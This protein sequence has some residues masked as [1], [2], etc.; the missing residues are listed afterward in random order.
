MNNE[1]NNT[2]NINQ[3]VVPGQI[4]QQV[5]PTQPTVVQPVVQ[6]TVPVQSVVQNTVQVQ[7]VQP[8]QQV[9]PQTVTQVP[10]QPT[11]TVQQPINNEAIICPKCNARNPK[12][13]ATCTACGTLLINSQTTETNNK[14]KAMF[15]DKKN[16]MYLGIGVVILLAIIL[17]ATYIIKINIRSQLMYNGYTETKTGV[18]KIKELTTQMEV[19]VINGIEQIDVS[20]S[21][22]LEQSYLTV[23]L[24]MNNLTEKDE[25]LE[26]WDIELVDESKKT[27]VTLNMFSE[28]DDDLFKTIKGNTKETGKFYFDLIGFDDDNNLNKLSEDKINSI[29]YL[30]LSVPSFAEKNAN[31]FDIKL[32]DYFIEVK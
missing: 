18:L 9:I 17:T 15:S 28:E 27:I 26:L 2:N 24:E 4:P 23:K 8:V 11:V 13:T 21:D 19:R 30:K 29:K 25:V 20:D 1:T 10:E 3:N 6:N 32:E 7:S 16:R 5:V 14:K 12:L 31:D 22:D